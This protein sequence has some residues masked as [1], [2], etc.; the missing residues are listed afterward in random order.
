M[1]Y[2]THP[3]HGA[4]ADYIRWRTNPRVENLR[5]QRVERAI[6]AQRAPVGVVL[7]GG[8]ERPSV[9]GFNQKGLLHFHSSDD[10]IELAK[11]PVGNQNSLDLRVNPDILCD[12]CPE[13]TTY[14]VNIVGTECIEGS[15]VYDPLTCTLTLTLSVD[16]QCLC[17]VCGPIDPG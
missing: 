17:D 8:R 12:C 5:I 3:V 16:E 2:V 13:D 9:I 14:V 10:S 7:R 11:S 1:S 6:V 15:M 4:T